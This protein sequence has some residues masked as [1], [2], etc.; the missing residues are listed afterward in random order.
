MLFK[1]AFLERPSLQDSTT[2]FLTRFEKTPIGKQTTI[3]M[4][5]PVETCSGGN[6]Q[7]HGA[8]HVFVCNQI[9]KKLNI[10]KPFIVVGSGCS[11]ASSVAM[12]TS[13]NSSKSKTACPWPHHDALEN[14]NWS[15]KKCKCLDWTRNGLT[16]LP[17]TQHKKM[18]IPSN[19]TSRHNF[20]C[21][22][23]PGSTLG[24]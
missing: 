3:I 1:L 17:T 7:R 11:S 4:H 21:R 6:A 5:M 23:E 2:T 15:L 18:R 24:T 20:A 10:K 8:L 22:G 14:R 12:S 16:K 19:A 13:V 9:I